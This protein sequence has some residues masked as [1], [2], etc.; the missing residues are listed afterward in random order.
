LEV[1]KKFWIST[2][3]VL[4][5]VISIV[6][7]FLIAN[8]SSTD[9][10]IDLDFTEQITIMSGNTTTTITDENH[11]QD[12]ITLIQHGIRPWPPE[13]NDQIGCPFGITLVFEGNDRKVHVLPAT[14]D[15][16]VISIDG[17]MNLIDLGN[18][19]MLFDIIRK[20][21]DFSMV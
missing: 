5:I 20:Y 16:D 18:K 19:T 11:I 7:Y 21:I 1:K 12:V 17:R 3:G 10:L 14:D 9:L 8:H 6:T 13:L 4:I 2:V 15:C